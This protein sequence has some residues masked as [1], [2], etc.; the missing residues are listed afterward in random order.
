LSN[1]LTKAQ[2]LQG[3]MLGGIDYYSAC[4][5]LG[6]NPNDPENQSVRFYTKPEKDKPK[7]DLPEGWE[8]IFDNFKPKK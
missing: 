6:F 5:M 4:M 3:L 2:K 7:Y 8:N 1:E